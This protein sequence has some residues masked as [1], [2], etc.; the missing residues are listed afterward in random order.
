MI[1]KIIQL[2]HWL[3]GNTNTVMAFQDEKD[4][5]PILIEIHI[6]LYP[7]VIP[8]LI[9]VDKELDEIKIGASAYRMKN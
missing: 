7:G 1:W 6:T 2:G 4:I 5:N 3:L 9:W 8:T